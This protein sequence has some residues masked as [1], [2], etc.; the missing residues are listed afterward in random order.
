MA[1]NIPG[2]DTSP[3]GRDRLAELIAK[4]GAENFPVASRVL[5]RALRRDLL[6][7]YGFARMVDDAGDEDTAVDSA[8]RLGMLD[9]VSAELDRVWTGEPEWPVMRRLAATV[10]AHDIPAEPFH[11]LIEANRIDQRVARYATM[12]DLAEYCEYSANPVGAIVLYLGDR[13]TPER[14]AWSDRVCT[15]LQ[16]LE[17]TQDVGEDYGR[18]RVY[19][20]REVLAAAGVTDDAL[21]HEL[22]ASHTSPRLRVALTSMVDHA[23]SLLDDGVP[24]VGTLRGFIRWAVAGYVAGG[25][26]TAAAIEKAGYDVL[27]A[28][29]RPSRGRTLAVTVRL[30]AGRGP[31]RGGTR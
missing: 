30:A 15:A 10:R 6:A 28:T 11:K 31:A 27:R 20:P 18:G 14:L 19:L 1:A 16:I 12:A 24:L 9:A 5:P 17:H 29:P 2:A 25:V 23:R 3:A 7:V 13:A 8:Q 22:G 26:A 4:S 21:D